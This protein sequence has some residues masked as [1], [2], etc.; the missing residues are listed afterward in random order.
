MSYFLHYKLLVLCCFCLHRSQSL[1]PN[2]VRFLAKSPSW[3]DDLDWSQA[4]WQLVV[5]WLMQRQELR[6]CVALARFDERLLQDTTCGLLMANKPLM[7][8]CDIGNIEDL[9]MTMRYAFGELLFDTSRRCRPGL[10][11]FGV[12]CR[13]RA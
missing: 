13:R 6:F 12:R 9:T 10:E 1:S 5:P 8:S 11:L 3:E 2:D 7:A 4:N